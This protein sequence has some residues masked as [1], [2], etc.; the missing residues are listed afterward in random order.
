MAILLFQ[1]WASQNLNTSEV[2]TTKLCPHLKTLFELKELKFTKTSQSKHKKGAMNGGS[3]LESQPSGIRGRG[4]SKSEDTL[5]DIVS[6]RAA[7]AI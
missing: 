6:C 4:I 2:P 5:I 3:Y 7:R 1:Q